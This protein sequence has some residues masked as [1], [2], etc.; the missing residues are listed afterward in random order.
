MTWQNTVSVLKD[1]STISNEIEQNGVTL[2]TKISGLSDGLGVYE[3]EINGL[4]D[5]VNK[6]QEKGRE[7]LTQLS[8]K[9]RELAGVV[10]ELLNAGLG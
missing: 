2:K 10:S 3:E 9:A 5:E 8:T 1:M 6:A 7:A 4:V